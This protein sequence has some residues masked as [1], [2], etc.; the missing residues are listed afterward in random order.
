MKKVKQAIPK[1]KYQYAFH[2]AKNAI[3]IAL[4]LTPVRFALELVGLP[5]SAIFIIGL[6]WLTLGFSIYWGIKLSREKH[7]YLIL[8]LALL[9]YSPISRFPVALLWWVDTKW[10]IGTHYGDYFNNFGHALLNQIGY[11]SL[12]QIIPGFII[13]SITLAIMRYRKA[14]I[15]KTNVLENE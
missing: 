15:R 13:G 12:T 11:G 6:L 5:E 3:I 10:E 2:L 8:L 9:I 1:S 14:V 7:C 4:V